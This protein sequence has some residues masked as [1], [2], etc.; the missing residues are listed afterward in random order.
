MQQGRRGVA[1]EVGPEHSKVAA[2]CM[3]SKKGRGKERLRSLLTSLV[4]CLP[5]LP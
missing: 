2:M 5:Q 1:L 4:V 3:E